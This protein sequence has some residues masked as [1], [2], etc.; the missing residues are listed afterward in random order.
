MNGWGH[1]GASP[2]LLVACTAW[3]RAF[4]TSPLRL[5]PVWRRWQGGRWLTRARLLHA[6]YLLVVVLT[7][8]AGFFPNGFESNG[9]NADAQ[10]YRIPRLIHWWLADSWHWIE[11]GDA[12][13]NYSACGVEWQMLPLMILFRSDRLFFLLSW[14]PFLLLPGLLWFAL[15]SLGVVRKTAFAWLWVFPMG[16][17]YALQVGTFGND[18][19]ALGLLL[20]S[21]GFALWA[22]K[23]TSWVLLSLSGLAAALL[24][25]LKL[26]NLPLLLPLAFFIWPAI[27]SIRMPKLALAAFLIVAT[28]ASAVPIIVANDR[29]TKDWTGIASQAYPKCEPY[30]LRPSDAW[31][32]LRSNLSLWLADV[33]QI[34]C[35]PKGIAEPCNSWI[36]KT[37]LLDVRYAQEDP[38]SKI[39]IWHGVRARGDGLGF[40]VWALVALACFMSLRGAPR[41]HPRAPIS[42]VARITPVLGWIAWG[43]FLM[44]AGG[45]STMR[46]SAPYY[47]LVLVPFLRTPGMEALVIGKSRMARTVIFLPF[48]TCFLLLSR[49]L[50]YSAVAMDL[51]LFRHLGLPSE[52]ASC[53]AQ[54]QVFEAWKQL[55]PGEVVKIGKATFPVKL[56][57]EDQTLMFWQPYGQRLLV[58]IGM[59]FG[60]KT[61]PAAEIQYIIATD[62]GF[63]DRFGIS[64][65]EWLADGKGEILRQTTPSSDEVLGRFYLIR[66]K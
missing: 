21:L 2:L 61:P 39:K 63:R 25:G 32:G 49:Q 41:C 57:N 28:L 54:V 22:R 65:P 7:L 48:L 4:Q 43:V 60:S 36:Q 19:L 38:P 45:G 42:W 34:S 37:S 52:Q 17:V 55:I 18:G 15:R 30:S 33:L 20:A 50:V 58:D 56:L 5:R 27:R 62:S 53:K 35:M 12:R 16:Y 47:F 10:T 44:K 3:W 1:L 8:I 64:V 9:I 6:S 31:H 11:T 26:S 40:A 23:Y 51:P 66:L 13:S 29:F 14:F 46:L 24:T 59:P